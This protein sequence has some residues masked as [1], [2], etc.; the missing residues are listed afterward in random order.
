[1]RE[2]HVSPL[3]GQLVLLSPL[4]DQ[5]SCRWLA[6]PVALVLLPWV[7]GNV[8]SSRFQA[9]IELLFTIAFSAE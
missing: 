2:K 3:A 4:G 7:A 8:R 5:P 6:G 9:T 1:M